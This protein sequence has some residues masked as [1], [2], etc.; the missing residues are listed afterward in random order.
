ME[1]LTRQ[2]ILA[3]LDEHRIMTVATVR[4]DGWPQ[5]TTVGYAHDGLNLYFLCGSASQKAANLAHDDRVSLT[6]D[7]DTEQVMDIRGL[8]MA[9]HATVVSDKAEAEKA[10]RLI[11]ERYPPQKMEQPMPLPAPTDVCIFRV[12]PTLISVLD[13]TRGFGHSELVTV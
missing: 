10:L 5:A 12:N 8:S 7:H 4:P 13:Y 2:K 6:I 11:M 9:G 1:D 3:L